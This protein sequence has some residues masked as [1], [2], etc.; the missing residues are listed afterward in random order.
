MRAHHT[1]I[2]CC[3]DLWGHRAGDSFTNG[4]GNTE[5]LSV[6]TGR[7]LS[8]GLMEEPEWQGRRRED[9]A[10]AGRGACQ[11]NEHQQQE[12]KQEPGPRQ[13]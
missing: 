12:Q 11:R 13:G 1:N 3:L 7:G 4:T 8:V 9:F 6:A 5:S 2:G 10:R